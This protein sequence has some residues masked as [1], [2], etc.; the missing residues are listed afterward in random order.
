MTLREKQSLFAVAVAAL[1]NKATDLGFELTLGEAYRPPATAEYYEKQ[2]KGIKGSLHIDKLAIDLN[3]FDTDGNFLSD[4]ESHR[5]LG[6]WWEA[7]EI[8]D[9]T[10]CWGGRFGDGNHYSFAHNGK[11]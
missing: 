10:P 11:K 5:P 3:L 1:I 6:E 4:T 9:I 8:Q 2:G 7:L